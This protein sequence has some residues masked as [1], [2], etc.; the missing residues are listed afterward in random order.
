MLSSII[1]MAASFI[2]D[3]YGGPTML[4]ALLIGMSLN[5]FSEDERCK[6]GVL[7][8]SRTVLRVGVALLGLRI[9]FAN[10]MEL[11]YASIIGI[12]ATVACT[13]LFGV[14]MARMLK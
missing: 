10:V 5:F 8:M 9:M 6:R 7:L 1:A 2:S 14:L 12:L 13:I 4:L 11:G 3:H